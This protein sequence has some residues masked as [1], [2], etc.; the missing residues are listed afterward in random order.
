MV[1]RDGLS[2]KEQPMPRD[3]IT[4]PD[5][6]PQAAGF[7]MCRCGS[8]RCQGLHLVLYDGQGGPFAQ[9]VLTNDQAIAIGLEGERGKN[10]QSAPS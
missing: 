1:E 5:D 8:E 3:N 4:L 9:V 10:G 7:D 6:M 2:Q